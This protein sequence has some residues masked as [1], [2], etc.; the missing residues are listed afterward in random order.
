MNAVRLNTLYIMTEGAYL[1]RDG[2]TVRI[3]LEGQTAATIPIHMLESIACYGRVMVSPALMEL[4]TEKHV[5]VNFLSSQGRI[6]ARVDTP[7]SGGVRLRRAQFRKA[8]DL[9]FRLEIARAV[10][11]GKVQNCRANLLRSSRDAYASD[12]PNAQKLRDAAER[13]ANNLLQLPLAA[14]LDEVRGVEGDC[15]RVY[16]ENFSLMTPTAPPPLTFSARTRRPPRDPVNALLSLFYSVLT[17]DCA[18]AL[19]AA[20]LDPSVGFLHDERPGRPSLALD[21]VEEFRPSLVD[22]FVMTLINRRQVSP[23]DFLTRPGGGVELHDPARKRLVAAYQERKQETRIHPFIESE[24]HI[25][26]FP[27]IQA[28]ILARVIRGD[29]AHYVPALFR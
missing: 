13:L 2:E 6:L 29:L 23:E 3:E 9:A 26:R 15:A 27:A 21:L 8:D 16:F 10:V 24:E 17:H 5:A 1:H 20:G 18:S 7:G 22:R 11:A 28:K 25:G 19:S 12:H 4:C 14:T